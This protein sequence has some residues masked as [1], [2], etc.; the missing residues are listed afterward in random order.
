MK[1]YVLKAP[2]GSY[3]A[4]YM[5]GV[6]VFDTHSNAITLPSRKEAENLS[7]AFRKGGLR[8]PLEIIEEDL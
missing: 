2:D 4:G 1:Q 5:A 8:T 6:A 7:L 3:Y